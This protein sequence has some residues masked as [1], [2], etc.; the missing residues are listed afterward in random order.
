MM[1]DGRCLCVSIILLVFIS[2]CP[3][4]RYGGGH[5]AQDMSVL[6]PM[7]TWLLVVGGVPRTQD[8]YKPHVSLHKLPTC[9][10]TCR[11]TCLSTA[12]ASGLAFC[13]VSGPASCRSS[14]II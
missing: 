2:R 9:L 3:L 5:R 8:A 7:P 4:I 11:W 12:L 1:D 10:P 13:R 6:C 14:S